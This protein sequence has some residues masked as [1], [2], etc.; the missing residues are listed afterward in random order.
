M[1]YEF[2]DP[3]SET[4][5]LTDLQTRK[6]RIGIK[7]PVVSVVT[8]YDAR[9]KLS[10]FSGFGLYSLFFVLVK[11]VK[12]ESKNVLSPLLKFV[13]LRFKK[14]IL[15]LIKLQ[16]KEYKQNVKK[17]YFNILIKGLA[18]EMSEIVTDQFQFYSVEID[19]IESIIAKDKSE[20]DKQ[21]ESLLLISKDIKKAFKEL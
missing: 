11:K 15:R 8:R 5:N 9:I 12:K 13:S 6:K 10:S 17:S 4:I 19:N 3:N 16:I 18:D 21:K 2:F 1:S 14:E 20:K 7:P